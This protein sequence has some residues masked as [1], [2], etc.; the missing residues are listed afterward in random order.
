MK[1][2][3]VFRPGGPAYGL[4]VIEAGSIEIVSPATRDEP[5]GAAYGPVVPWGNLT[6]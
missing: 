2:E 4:L 6:C 3:V 5:E 1:P